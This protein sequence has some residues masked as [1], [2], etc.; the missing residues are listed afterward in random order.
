M[1]WLALDLGGTFGYAIHDGEYLYY[2]S[3]VLTDKNDGT[4]RSYLPAY[5]LKQWLEYAIH[6]YGF[7]HVAYED[8]FARGLAKFRLDSMAAAVGLFAIEHGLTWSRV[9][10]PTLKKYSTGNGHCGKIQMV[11]AAQSFFP[12]LE[13]TELTFD[14]ADAL[15]VLAWAKGM[16][17]C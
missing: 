4:G 17:R 8:T 6:R 10:V 14:E 9:S 7:D 11:E 1:S 15:C 16:E 2:G 3:D 5:R 12:C 13:N